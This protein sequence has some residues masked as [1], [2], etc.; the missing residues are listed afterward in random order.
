MYYRLPVVVTNHAVL[1][2]AQRVDY[3]LPTELIKEKIKQII[4]PETGQGIGKHVQIVDDI[5]Y[6]VSAYN[7]VIT[8]TNTAKE[9]KEKQDGHRN[10]KQNRKCDSYISRQRA[11]QNRPK[12]YTSNDKQRSLDD[13]VCERDH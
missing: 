7:E 4:N 8:V 11:I 10:G 1:R 12:R 13:W 9:N 6:V 3:L 5:R 2:Y